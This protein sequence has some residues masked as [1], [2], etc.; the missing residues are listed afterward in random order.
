MKVKELIQKLKEFDPEQQVLCY[1]ED[2]DLR[3]ASG[4]V[5]I[6][7]I[8]DIDETTAVRTKMTDGCGKWGLTFDSKHK[9]SEK[10]VLI[11][12]TSVF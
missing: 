10:F 5:Q 7:E 2:K 9:D 4:P 3:S 6:F 1:S 12:G 11:A 8:E